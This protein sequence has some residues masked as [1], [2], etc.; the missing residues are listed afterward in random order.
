MLNPE[1]EDIQ[2]GFRSA[3]EVVKSA[4]AVTKLLPYQ[5][6]EKKPLIT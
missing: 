6:F 1:L 3:T 2:G 5:T 4:A